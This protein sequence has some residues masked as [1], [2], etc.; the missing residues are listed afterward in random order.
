VTAAPGI[1]NKMES[2]IKAFLDDT[3]KHSLI[4][5]AIRALSV[6]VEHSS[7]KTCQGLIKD[8]EAACK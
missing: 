3:Q 4:F 1:V 5:G 6:V 8:I 2:Y 7:S